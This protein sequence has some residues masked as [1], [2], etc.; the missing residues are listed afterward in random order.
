MKYVVYFEDFKGKDS[1]IAY[2]KEQLKNEVADLLRDCYEVTK[3][4]RIVKG[5]Y[6]PIDNIKSYLKK[7]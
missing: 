4:C 7:Y 1:L 6:I 2:S 3:I 5:E